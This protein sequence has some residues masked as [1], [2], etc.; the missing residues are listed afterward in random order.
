[1]EKA[2][3]EKLTEEIIAH[4]GKLAVGGA[5]EG[6]QPMVLADL[7]RRDGGRLVYIARDASAAI[8][9]RDM[10]AFFAPDIT[11]LYLPAWDCLPYDRLS[12]QVAVM[13]ERMAT[14]AQLPLLDGQAHILITTISAAAQ[15]LPA[16]DKL[17]GLSLAMKPGNVIDVDAAMVMRAAQL[18]WS[19]AIMPCAAALSTFMRRAVIRRCVSIYL[20]T[21]WNPSARLRLKASA[22][23]AS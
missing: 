8:A 5:P 3:F 13:S 1:M 22:Q 17:A 21:R 9:I 16:R 11:T 14:L 7:A 23:L 4:Q 15:R 2:E 20:A 12:P 18:L 19:R 6:Y 10:L